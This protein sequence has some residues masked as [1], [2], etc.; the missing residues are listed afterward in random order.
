MHIPIP[1]R[2]AIHRPTHFSACRRYVLT[3]S[4]VPGKP[5]HPEPILFQPEDSRY[6]SIYSVR[7]SNRKHFLSSPFHIVPASPHISQ[8]NNLGLGSPY[9]AVPEWHAWRPLFRG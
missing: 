9:V 7:H 8:D 6:P 1:P 4:N 2:W 5:S 3:D